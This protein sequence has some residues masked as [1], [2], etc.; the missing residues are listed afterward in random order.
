VAGVKRILH[1]VVGGL[2]LNDEAIE[3]PAD[4]GLTMSVY[5][6][7]PGSES[8]QARD[9]LASWTATLELADGANDTSN[10]RGYR[11]TPYHPQRADTRAAV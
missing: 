8:A 5:T 3:L 10:S 1:P 2:R 7:E 9:I 4:A 6:A 11:P